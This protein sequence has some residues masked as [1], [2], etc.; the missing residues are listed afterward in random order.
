MSIELKQL[1]SI[2]LTCLLAA[3][4]PA[5]ADCRC[6]D[7]T[8]LGNNAGECRDGGIC[9]LIAEEIT[10][11]KAD[12]VVP[13]AQNSSRGTQAQRAQTAQTRSSRIC[14]QLHGISS[15]D[16]LYRCNDGSIRENND[17]P[18]GNIGHLFKADSIACKQHDTSHPNRI[19]L[20]EFIGK[21]NTWVPGTAYS[22]D[23][24]VNNVRVNHT[25]TGSAPHL[26]LV[27]SPNGT[28]V[29]KG[30]RGTW[31]VT[32]DDENPIVLYRAVDGH[33]WQVSILENWYGYLAL[34]DATN[35]G[36]YYYGKR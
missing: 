4:L 28:Y 36:I 32:N 17:C 34:S 18:D 7:G 8:I 25:S 12:N 14:T 33:D 13:S 23:D 9:H 35:S 22:V 2:S 27:I 10:H 5:W 29:W 20:S 6:D 15:S 24:Y 16:F 3:A 1:C 31:G 19:A 11:F 21:W 26:D 30:I